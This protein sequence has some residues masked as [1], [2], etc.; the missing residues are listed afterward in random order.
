MGV[1]EEGYQ[2]DPGHTVLLKR[3]LKRGQLLLKR[4]LLLILIQL[5]LGPLLLELTEL[6]GKKLIFL[7]GGWL[8]HL[9]LLPQPLRWGNRWP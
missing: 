7:A 2:T 9:R 3:L 4:P 6:L 5:H 8:N 1:E